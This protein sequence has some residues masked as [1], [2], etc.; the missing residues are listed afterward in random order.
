METPDGLCC[1][2]EGERLLKKDRHLFLRE[3][4]VSSTYFIQLIAG[5]KS[6][7]GKGGIAACYHDQMDIGWEM[8]KEKGDRFVDLRRGN[9]MVIFQNQYASRWGLGQYVEQGCQHGFQR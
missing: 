4:E 8:I 3:T 7:Q 2:R 1:E 6:C 5:T 9:D